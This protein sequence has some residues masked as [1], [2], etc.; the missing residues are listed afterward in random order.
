MYAHKELCMI[1]YMYKSAQYDVSLH[2]YEKPCKN[3]AKDRFLPTCF[4]LYS[5]M[6]INRQCR[7]WM[8]ETFGFNSISNY[9]QYAD[10]LTTKNDTMKVLNCYIVIAKLWQFMENNNRNKTPADL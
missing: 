3:I 4:W 9:N 6:Q 10:F 5:K 7:K 8:E 2:H 1:C